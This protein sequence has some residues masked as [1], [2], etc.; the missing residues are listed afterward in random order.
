[1]E[2]LIARQRCR[3]ARVGSPVAPSCSP[4]PTVVLI[5][6]AAH[7]GDAWLAVGRD[8]A[9]AGYTVL[10]PDLPGHGLSQGPAL[11]SIDALANW[12]V[13]LLDAVGVGRAL[14]VGHSMGALIA[15]ACAARHPQRVSRLALLGASVPM[16]VADHL[17]SLAANDS[18]AVCRLM[19]EYSVSKRFLLAGSGGHGIWGPG[20]TLAIMRRSPSGVLAVDLALCNDYT[21]GLE[22]ASQ[23]ECPALL[24]VGRRDRM[25]PRR[26]M[27][28][29]QSALTRV[30][31]I[32]I[33]DCGH[34]LL[35]EQPRVVARELL[36][37]FSRHGPESFTP[38]SDASPENA[39]E[40]RLTRAPSGRP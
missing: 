36:S 34:A 25:T 23:V 22:A 20:M 12:V 13:A 17:L 19:T 26:N 35:S 2:L 39:Q 29:L 10:A 15:L 27:A 14:L 4:L 32:E 16:P 18:D 3:L 21:A 40:R 7:D 1:M 5:H 37:F 38:E 8:L 9:V 6:G 28:P 31:R 11:R 33:P 24:L 30:E